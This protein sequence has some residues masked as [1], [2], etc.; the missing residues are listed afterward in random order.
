MVNTGKNLEDYA[1]YVYSRL[2]ELSD[3][4]NVLVST[5]VT[6]KG[7]SGATNE[8]DVYYQFNHLNVE[9]RVAIE[10]KDW[11][12]KVSIKEIRDFST[13]LQDV[14]LGNIIGVMI[15][16]HGFQEGTKTFA[17]SHGIR[18]MTVEEFPTIPDIVAGTLKKGFLPDEKVLG[19][20]F[21]T[22]MEVRDNKVTGTYYSVGTKEQPVI[23]LFY[24]KKIVEALLRILPDSSDF[25]VRGISR[26]QLRGLINLSK[27]T[28]LQ[29][30]I[31][32][33]PYFSLIFEGEIQEDIGK[34]PLFITTA[35]NIE[36]N[37]LD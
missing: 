36:E 19:E 23:P 25:A 32:T 2:L 35:K 21:W 8:F 1:Q 9:C 24:S 33:L 15:S 30:A 31:C 3:Y 16:K 27:T 12:T 20:P 17:A 28:D 22:L 4:E 18:L 11:K 26:Y 14:G 7:Q 6:I 5:K 37:Y 10:C 13:K 29:F 34:L